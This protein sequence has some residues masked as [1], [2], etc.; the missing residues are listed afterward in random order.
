MEKPE[1]KKLDFTTETILGLI[2]LLIA[3]SC[4]F[5]GLVLPQFKR[6]KAQQL[7]PATYGLTVE[8]EIHH[9]DGGV[10]RFE[11]KTESVKFIP[12]EYIEF[13]T[14][15][16]NPIYSVLPFSIAGEG[17]EHFQNPPMQDV[18]SNFD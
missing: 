3:G 16:G 18:R 13:I 5:C 12:K 6:D 15:D 2:I 1:P 14:V 11:A 4:F 10:S 9:A 7:D 17:L 8:V